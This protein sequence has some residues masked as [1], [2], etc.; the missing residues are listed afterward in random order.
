[1]AGFFRLTGAGPGG[2]EKN[3]KKMKKNFEPDRAGPRPMPV[4]RSLC[5]LGEEDRSM[6]RMINS[7]LTFVTVSVNSASSAFALDFWQPLPACYGQA[8]SGDDEILFHNH[9]H[10]FFLSEAV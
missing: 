5:A 1:M 2:D 9:S 7:L 4:T 10:L 8:I 3:M 6:S